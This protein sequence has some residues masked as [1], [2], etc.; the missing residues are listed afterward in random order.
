VLG[1][2]VPKAANWAVGV[3]VLGAVVQYEVCQASLRQEREKMRRIVK[4]YD[5]KQAEIKAAEAER[6]R[7]AR[8]RE[9]EEARRKAE[10]RWWKVW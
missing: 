10:R 5:Q 9:E 6:I 8:A 7:A 1:A 3:G 4:V 2:G